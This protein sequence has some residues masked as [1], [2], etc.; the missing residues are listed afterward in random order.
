MLRFLHKHAMKDCSPATHAHA[1]TVS[2]V[3]N[4]RLLSG[5]TRQASLSEQRAKSN[6]E[7]VERGNR[8]LIYLTSWRLLHYEMRITSNRKCTC[9]QD[10][11]RGHKSVSIGTKT[12]KVYWESYNIEINS[13]IITRPLKFEGDLE[14]KQTW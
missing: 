7:E 13:K 3:V 11:S 8:E 1:E 10:M 2:H 9:D 5:R 4:V 6:N 12:N 14:G